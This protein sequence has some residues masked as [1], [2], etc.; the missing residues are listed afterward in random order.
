[1]SQLPVDTTAG[2]I[3]AMMGRSTTTQPI[4]SKE[5]E[6]YL[7]MIKDAL[8]VNGESEIVLSIVSV[9]EY[10]DQDVYS[11][12]GLRP[13]ITHQEI[14][15]LI[16]DGTVELHMVHMETPEMGGVWALFLADDWVLIRVDCGDFPIPFYKC[17]GITGTRQCLEMVR[18]MIADM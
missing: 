11:V 13:E 12:H 9:P 6:L 7:A 10:S 8:S 14:S 15:A 2:I 5:A 3:D 4:T 17:D 18:G 1:L 16:S